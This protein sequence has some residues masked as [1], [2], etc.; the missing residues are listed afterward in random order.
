MNHRQI[1]FAGLAFIT[2]GAANSAYAQVKEVED[3]NALTVGI[4]AAVIPSYEGSDDY[5][6]IPVPQLR[7]KVSD[8]AFWTRG[9]SL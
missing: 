5:R 8:F 4:G 1:V 3:S 2:L 7:G 9:P 6:V